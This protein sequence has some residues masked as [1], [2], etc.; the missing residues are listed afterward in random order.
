MILS[1]LLDLPVED[2]SGRRLGGV[3]DVRFVQGAAAN[4]LRLFGLLVSPTSRASSFG[5]E[6]RNVR[7]PAPIAWWERR[8][9][10]GMFLVRWED[11]GP[12]LVRLR[13]G[14]RRYS[15]LLPEP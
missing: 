11:V 9:H 10:R 6:R 8:R 4:D 1:D 14:F 3:A 13:E 12:R 15:A 5:Y 2:G 7:A